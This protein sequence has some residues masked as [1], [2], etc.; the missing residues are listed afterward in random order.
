M[1]AWRAVAAVA[2]FLA[3]AGCGAPEK[4]P[5]P[6]RA[7][8]DARFSAAGYVYGKEPVEFLERHVGLLPRGKALD[9]AAGE[10][11]NAVFLARNGFEVVAVDISEVGLRKAEALASE[12][13]VRI[14]TVQADLEEYDLGAEAYDVV[15]NLYYLQRSL[16]PRIKRALKPGGVVVFEMYTLDNLE[17]PGAHGPRD[18][19]FLLAPGELRRLFDDFEL[20]RW[21]ETRDEKKAVASLLARKRR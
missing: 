1:S 4:T 10:G 7:R 2:A 8:W 3:G 13:G 14:R 15:T 9:L 12:R 17:I 19:A 18:R 6:A 21:S 20:L 5:N 11:R 16:I